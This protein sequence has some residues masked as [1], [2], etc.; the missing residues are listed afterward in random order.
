MVR[1]YVQSTGT[2]IASNFKYAGN[3]KIPQQ[4]RKANEN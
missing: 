3:E 2:G 1:L 4:S